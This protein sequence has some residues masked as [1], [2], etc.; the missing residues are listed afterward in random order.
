[1]VLPKYDQ[2]LN[3]KKLTISNS[4]ILMGPHNLR[5]FHECERARLHNSSMKQNC[6]LNFRK[7]EKLYI[8]GCISTDQHL[9]TDVL[10]LLIKHIPDMPL[11]VLSIH[12]AVSED[13][14]RKLLSG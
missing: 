14:L 7:L 8:Q 11:K 5:L 3:V 2:K 10:D 6:W 13:C 12:A 9:M 1:M 4:R